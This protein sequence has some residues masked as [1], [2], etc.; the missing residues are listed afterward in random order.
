MK[1]TKVTACLLILSMFF[2][3]CASRAAKEDGKLVVYVSF[4]VMEDFAKRLC[5]EDTEVRLL[6]P[7]GTE[8]HDWEPS[9]RD[10]AGMADADLIVMNGL[11]MEGWADKVRVSLPNVRFAVL[12]DGIGV[13]MH[14]EHD[15]HEH[16]D[17]DHDDYDAHSGH[18]HGGVDPHVWLNPLYALAEM[19]NLRDALAAIDPANEAWYNERLA[20]FEEEAMALHKEFEAALSAAGQRHIV[21]AHQAYGYLCEAYGL[22]QTA[23]EGLSANGE[24]S[25]AR[26]AEIID[27]IRANEIQ[28]IF[29]EE[30]LPSKALD[31]IVAETGVQMLLLSPME[32]MNAHEDYFSVMRMNLV[33]LREALRP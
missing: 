24:P 16:D 2:G 15:E 11:G 27:F 6:V 4:A 20:A 9:P 30:L 12:S 18:D 14:S 10:M 23:V 28:H 3:G 19:R 25:P 5:T 26:I 17:H 32:Y 7:S 1:L 13:D 22:E 31:V 33:N 21:V 29:F 8:P